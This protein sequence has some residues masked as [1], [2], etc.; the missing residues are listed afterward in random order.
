MLTH[1]TLISAEE[2]NAIAPEAKPKSCCAFPF[3]SHLPAPMKL[4]LFSSVIIIYLMPRKNIM[5]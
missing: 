5:L 3:R 4:N 1:Y 2:K